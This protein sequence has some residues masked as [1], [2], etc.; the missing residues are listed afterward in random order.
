MKRPAAALLLLALDACQ[1]PGPASLAEIEGASDWN[2]DDGDALA[3]RFQ[4]DMRRLLV[5][6]GIGDALSELRSEGYACSTEE[7]HQDHPDPVS[8][9]TKSFATRACQ[10]D[11]EVSLAAK[12]AVTSSVDTG[13]ARDCV[14]LDRD[15]PDARNSAIDNQ[16]A[17]GK[18]EMS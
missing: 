4:R 16:A 2:L 9:C 6:R 18:R 11:W 10:I 12:G 1:T 5:G 14:G 13:F 17:L 15:W 3:Y 7:A 8:V